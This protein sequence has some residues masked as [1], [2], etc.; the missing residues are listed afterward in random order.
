[1]T[2][3]SL[4]LSNTEPSL[5]LLTTNQNAKYIYHEIRKLGQDPS[6]NLTQEEEE[7]GEINGQDF[8]M[9]EERDEEF[10][11][12]DIGKRSFLCGRKSGAFKFW[13]WYRN[14]GRV[15]LEARMNHAFNIAQYMKS[16]LVYP[17]FKLVLSNIEYLNVCFWFIPPSLQL[18]SAVGDT[19]KENTHF[20]QEILGNEEKRKV[21]GETTILMQERLRSHVMIDFTSLSI[22]YCSSPSLEGNEMNDTDEIENLPEFFRPVISSHNIS[23]EDIDH[24]VNLFTELGSDL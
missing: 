19:T 24:M 21:L 20:I 4:S 14:V 17:N 6:S 5:L 13:L 15:G 1:M 7:K 22:P 3:K 8:L 12:T 18:S 10:F 23:F 11:H 2:N 9:V 16:R